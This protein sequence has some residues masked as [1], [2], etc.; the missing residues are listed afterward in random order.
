MVLA[1]AREINLKDKVGYPTALAQNSG[2]DDE[3]P[4]RPRAIGAPVFI[5]S[6]RCATAFA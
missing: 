6:L 2:N 5:P 3:Q 1:S 4:D